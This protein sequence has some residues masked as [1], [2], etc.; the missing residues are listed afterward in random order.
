MHWRTLIS[1]E[2]LAGQL[3]NP[4]LVVV[5]CRFDLRDPGAG[6]RAYAA[7]HLPGAHYAHLDRD[8]SDLSRH[9]RGRH[10]LPE[11][12]AFC[13]TLARWGV[14]ANHQVVAYDANDGSVAARLW[15]MLR[16]LG[17]DRVA[18]LNGGL[19]AWCANAYALE[20]TAPR[21]RP[22]RDHARYDVRAMA[23]TAVIAARMASGNSKL[24]DARAAERFRGEIEPIDAIAGHIPGAVNRPFV[25]NLGP[26]GRFKSPGVLAEEFKALLGDSPSNET[27]LMCG[28]GVTAC[29]HLLAMEHAGLRGA[30]VYPGSWSEWISD[31]A[32][33]V[34]RA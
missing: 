18:V 28:S 5:D 14:T 24:I 34:A 11:A 9:G 2:E 31:P 17:H 27:L 26:D 15:W 1:A 23:S 33:P 29:H 3:A 7:G 8:L 12:D 25:Q 32:R 4:E 13:A 16:L 20:A 22:G 10:P 21:S 6:E 19:A 30:R